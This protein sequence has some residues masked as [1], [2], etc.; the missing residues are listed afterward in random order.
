MSDTQAK[1]ENNDTHWG[2]ST[3]VWKTDNKKYK[4]QTYRMLYNKN[5]KEKKLSQG[6]G[7]GGGLRSQTKHIGIRAEVKILGQLQKVITGVTLY[8]D[9]GRKAHQARQRESQVQRPQSPICSGRK[10]VSLEQSK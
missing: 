9:I 10:L 6:R 3:L 7:W 1:A 2:R 4:E 5:A 8:A